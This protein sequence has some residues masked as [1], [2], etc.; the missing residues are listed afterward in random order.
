MQKHLVAKDTRN[1]YI[2]WRGFID[3]GS[4]THSKTMFTFLVECVAKLCDV[5]TFCQLTI[6]TKHLETLDKCSKQQ[7]K[8]EGRELTAM[9]TE[10]L[11][12][13]NITAN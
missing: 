6:M 5:L 2:S 12:T 3:L 9:R 8:L 1:V 7:V 4:A 13:I 10:H 11:W